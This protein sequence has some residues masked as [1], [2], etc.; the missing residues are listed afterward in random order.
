MRGR[1]NDFPHSTRWIILIGL[2]MV[3]ATVIWISRPRWH[4]GDWREVRAYRTNWDY[5][6][7]DVLPFVDTEGNFEQSQ[8][9][10]DG[11]LLSSEQ[12]ERL[13]KAVLGRHKR[14]PVLSCHYPHHV[15]VFTD[16]NGQVV[17]HLSICFIC[18]SYWGSPS[19]YAYPWDLN[20]IEEILVEL[21]IPLSNP[22]WYEQ[23]AVKA[24]S[25]RLR[26]L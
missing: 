25:G 20:A 2:F 21:G 24:S 8:N 23:P 16:E 13:K 1:L 6:Q 26:D 14:H 11:I 22:K 15:F 3:L 17:G 5:Y 7:P 18:S 19:G 4:F 10:L 12:I 9:P